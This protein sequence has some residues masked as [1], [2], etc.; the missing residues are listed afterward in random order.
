MA[1]NLIRNCALLLSYF[2]FPQYWLVQE[3]WTN[4]AVFF[5]FAE[6]FYCHVCLYISLYQV[7]LFLIPLL[8]QYRGV[9]VKKVSVYIS[10]E[11]LRPFSLSSL[12]MSLSIYVTRKLGSKFMQA[13]NYSKMTLKCSLEL[14]VDNHG[15]LFQI[16]S[17]KNT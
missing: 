7:T 17:R 4:F 8:I 16:L 14:H 12:D 10:K 6:F 1:F 15:L 13:C 9:K 2:H 11:A 5:F 3:V